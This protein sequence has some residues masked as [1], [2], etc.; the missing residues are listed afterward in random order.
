MKKEQT[1][2]TGM[3]LAFCVMS[4]ALA[5][6]RIRESAETIKTYPFFDADPVPILARSDD[7]ED[8]ARLYPYH[9]FDGFSE[10]GEKGHWAV[11]R[12]ENPY[13]KV[14]VLPEVGGKIWG[15]SEKSTGQE[16]IY[17]NKVL[18]FRQ[19]ALRGPW[20]SGGVEFN[21]GVVGHAPSCATPV[22]YL[23]RKNRDGSV[24]CIV[25]TMDLP[26]RTRWAVNIMLPKDKAFVETRAFCYNPT[27]LSQSY[28]VWM[29]GAVEAAGDLQSTL[30]GESFIG[31]DF[32][33]KPQPWPVDAQGRDLSWYRN[34]RFGSHKSYFTVGEYEDSY[35]GYWHD[36]RFGLG[37]WARYDDVPGQKLWLWALSRQGGIWEDL[38]TDA[39]GQYVEP[40]AG[41]YFNQN[42]HGLF[43]PHLTDTWREIWF[44]YKKI[45]PLVKASPSGVLSVTTSDASV[46]VGVCAFE[47]VLDDLVVTRDNREVFRRRLKLSPMGVYEEE[48]PLAMDNR[49]FEV[50]VG[51]KIRYSSDPE[52]K[53]LSRPID[54]RESAGDTTEELFL[55]AERLETSRRYQ[56]A[57]EGYEACLQ[58]EPLHMRALCRIAELYCRRGEYEKGL[59]YAERA[60]S[61]SM[62]DPT[63]NYVYGV[64]SRRQ[65]RLIDAKETFGWAA[66][67]MEY[68][69]TAYGQMAEIHLLERNHT[70]AIEYAR[71]ALDYNRF[72]VNAHQLLISTFRII[73]QTREARKQIEQLHEIDPLN[74]FGRFE[75]YLLKPTA[76]L[77]KKFQSM[78]RNEFPRE[79][80]LELALYY[81]RIG[82]TDEAVHV[83]KFVQ[84]FP[85]ACYWVAYLLRESPNES[86]QYLARTNSLSPR[87]VFP[88]REETIPV[89]QW[90]N[91]CCPEDW[92]AKYYLALIYWSRGRIEE[93]REL[94]DRCGAPSFTPMLI[95]RAQVNKAVDTERAISDLR[96]AIQV[97]PKS[98]RARHHLIKYYNR[99]GRLEESLA[100][101]QEAAS[102][103]PDH[104]VIQSDLVRTLVENRCWKQAL[105]ILE[106]TT[107]LPFEG[108]REMHGLFVECQVQLALDAMEIGQYA[109]AVEHLSGAMQYPEHLG[110]GRPY[111]P[112]LRLQQFLQALCYDKLSLTDEAQ[113]ARQ[114]IYDYTLKHMKG[115]GSNQ[116]FG[117][118]VLEHF[119]EHD[120]AE[121]LKNIAR[122]PQ[123]I[124]DVIRTVEAVQDR[125]PY[126]TGT[127]DA[128]M[129]GNHRVVIDVSRGK[130]AVAVHVP[131][132]RRDHAPEKKKVIFV[133][134]TTGETL[135][136]VT[137]VEINREF[138]NFVFKPI[139]MP[140]K[141]Y[142]YYRPYRMTGRNYPKVQYEEV[143]WGGGTTGRSTDVRWSSL[144]RASVAEIQAIDQFNSFYPMEVIATA[145]ETRRLK[146]QVP[147]ASFLLF[148]EDRRHPIRMTDDLPLRWVEKGLRDSFEGEGLRGEFYAFQV[149]VYA[150]GETISDIDVEFGDLLGPDGYVI[151]SSAQRCF[152]TGGMDWQGRPFEK[153]CQVE[154]GKVRA[155]WCGISIPKNARSGRY[156]GAVTITPQ[157][158]KPRAIRIMLNVKDEVLEDAGDSQPWRHSRLRW[159]DSKIAIDDEMVKPFV[160]LIVD[161]R[162]I[163]CLGRQ[164]TLDDKGFPESFQSQFAPEVTHLIDHTREVLSGPVRFVVN[165]R[166]GEQS[167]RGTRGLR[168]VKKTA[169]RVAWE[170]QSAAG[171]LS[172][173]CRGEMECDGFIGYTVEL[174]ASEATHVKDIRLEIPVVKDV[175]K[176]IMGMGLKG[177]LRRGELDWNWD[178]NKNHDSVWLGDTNAGL[179]C[180]FRAE[181]YSRPLNTNFYLLKP[182]N[183]PPSWYNQGQGGCRIAETAGNTVLINAYSGPRTLRP[184]EKLYFNFTLLLTPFKPIDDKAQWA[185]RFY[186]SY[187]PIDEIAEVGANTINT[188]HANDANPYINYPFIHTAQMKAYVDEAH[189][190][191]MKVKIYYTVRELSNR[192]AELF[193]LRSLDHE[194][195]S[196]GPGGGY[197][198]L[199]EH[200]GSDYIAGWY[201]PRYEDAAVI[202]SG[203][204]RWHNYYLEGLNWLVDNI[205]IDGLYIDDV[206]F[207]RTVMKRV[208]K[209]LDRARPGALIDLHSANQY[210]VRD[211]FVNSAN[212]YLEH[213]PYLNRLWFGEYFDYN[214][215]PDFW[216]VEVSGIC[217]GLMGEMLQDGGNPWRGMLY[218]MTA[219]LPREQI[220][221]RLWKLWDDF[222]M[223]EAKTI[224]Y[225]SNAC[226]V[227]TNHKDV[228]ATV[229]QRDGKALISI[230][231]WAPDT[232]RCR[233][234]IDWQ[235]LGINKRG[236]KLTAPF[237]EGFQ[238]AAVF[239]PEEDIP[240][241]P[242]KG[243]LLILK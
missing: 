205:E 178:P 77:L 90:A 138:G 181:N 120:R 142:L 58:A 237:I 215:P 170:K 59:E 114:T 84:D 69:S 137:A 157:G 227:K 6:A 242:G 159:L 209:I 208:R 199:Q 232:V 65:G 191:G 46:K 13:V 148:P 26:S 115:R 45:G 167:L 230:A 190:K 234:K 12:M 174:T 66:R 231:S 86:R 88:F 35:G 53:R 47:R 236:A 3:L 201:V 100:L 51:T 102:D 130:D 192:C 161:G 49:A 132:R 82:L 36:K 177:G 127:W 131:W 41:R 172:L 173:T 200:L 48:I 42:D 105:D 240:V 204:S 14:A 226:P 143:D 239:L 207:D 7:W 196:D 113:A 153:V 168:F 134:A 154:K 128:N 62:Y 24:S 74:H 5:A 243:W 193:A 176:Y 158:D 219:R 147:D 50:A 213:F 92:K 149:G 94:L 203:V 140:G 222:G 60:L 194:I 75:Q 44:P 52:A 241:V 166:Q 97:D 67:S 225:W 124:L 171:A 1:W 61:Q 210:N 103:F 221:A 202:N 144:P 33:V 151:D 10:T 30:P 63:A 37:H 54:F 109:V 98:W 15:A 78:V 169:G 197:S 228:L 81:V 122:P 216:L 11:V 123:E 217:F 106:T 23:T 28:Y 229:Y 31:H 145:A 180:A 146:A 129:L 18:K 80:Y 119:G 155:L 68:R 187:K 182:L 4:S 64:L 121:K 79:T 116:Y 32:S 135:K 87:G 224:G 89:L 27:S 9:F 233:L 110:T 220:P 179:Q 25:G 22:D 195:L 16:F 163:S 38:L 126:G 165:T 112:D 186:H 73:G 141:V 184:G 162:T 21:F 19:I 188:H 111:D 39:D 83:L 56:S 104:M 93:A 175:A 206:A 136:N 223:Q 107:I 117:A 139:T 99:L 72:N 108:A 212:L 101:A 71:R 43:A 198:W 20:T 85:T 156:N 118:L 183:M 218:G 57:L 76:S 211:G 160:P 34:N 8:N 189:A 235:A 125:V 40:Q 164:V 2:V 214:S 150:S 29:N 152:N 185:T 17:T 133:D 70:L 95:T 91:Q 55:K 238:E 96:T